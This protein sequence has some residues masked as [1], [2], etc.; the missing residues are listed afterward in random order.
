MKTKRLKIVFISIL[1]LFIILF[2]IFHTVKIKR[3]QKR[4]SNEFPSI[5][6][7]SSINGIITEIHHDDLTMFRDNP[8]EAGIIIDDTL[9]VS[10]TADKEL[11]NGMMLDEIIDKGEFVFKERGS[12][13]ISISKVQNGDTIRYIFKLLDNLLY[14]LKNK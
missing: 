14:P 1:F 7:E 9:K 11:T 4:V 3:A 2:Y 12:D 10:I 13:T 8:Y 6:L 5:E